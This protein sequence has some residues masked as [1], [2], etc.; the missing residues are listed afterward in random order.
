MTHHSEKEEAVQATKAE[1]E[2]LKQVR[3]HVTARNGHLLHTSSGGQGSASNL[4][5]YAWWLWA[6]GGGSTSSTLASRS[7]PLWRP[8]ASRST[9]RCG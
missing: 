2:R 8:S 7:L 1:V 6:G 5:G 3:Q 9:V 4:P